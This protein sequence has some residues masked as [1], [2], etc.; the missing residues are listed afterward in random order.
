MRLH[1]ARHKRGW[2]NALSACETAPALAHAVPSPSTFA[3][4]TVYDDEHD[5]I[6]SWSRTA[7]LDRRD[8]P[9]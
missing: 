8:D 5:R 7:S 4:I 6:L 2:S 3:S 1:Y 9:I